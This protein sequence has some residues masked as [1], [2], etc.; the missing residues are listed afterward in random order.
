MMRYILS[1]AVLFTATVSTNSYAVENPNESRDMM[2]E[3]GYG[4]LKGKKLQK[5][6]AVA[7][8]HDLGSAKNPVRE[9]MPQG[10][11]AYLARLRCADGKRPIFDRAGSVGNSPYGYIMDKYIVTCEG[12]QPMDVYMDMYH[13]GGAN[14]P[15]PAFTITPV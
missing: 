10:E 6:I 15:L 9:N 11:T 1:I 7:E 3:L 5:A 14:R 12:Q 8:A 4:G 13:D 2:R